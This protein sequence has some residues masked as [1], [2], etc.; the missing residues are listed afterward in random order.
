M[1][2]CAECGASIVHLYAH[3]RFCSD[4]CGQIAR[5]ERRRE[6]LPKRACEWCDK[7]FQPRQVDH[8]GCCPD[9]AARVSDRRRR[10]RVKQERPEV[11]AGWRLAYRRRLAADPARAV[12]E[13]ER[14][15]LS[16]RKREA[17]KRANVVVSFTTAELEA[18][19]SMFPGC[20]ICGSPD[21]DQ[22]DHVKPIA[23]GG[24]H[25]LANLRPACG[26]C[27]RRKWASWEGVSMPG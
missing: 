3:A 6:Q 8:R 27:N 18:R 26:L 5:G 15:R 24:P 10:I 21:P 7:V 14:K 11:F 13:R 4:R 20:W 22:I 16:Q 23:R 25:V 9:H 19:L 2:V 12:R 1:R 17:L